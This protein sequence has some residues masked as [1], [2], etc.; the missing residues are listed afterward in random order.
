MVP[1]K[2][3]VNAD[4]TSPLKMD[5]TQCILNNCVSKYFLTLIF[6]YCEHSMQ[7][8]IEAKHITFEVK[9]RG[10]DSALATY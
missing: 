4:V 7:H 2:C 5:H 9:M 10:L 1:S 8:N 6:L 3:T